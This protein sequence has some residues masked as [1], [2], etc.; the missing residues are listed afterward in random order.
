MEKTQRIDVA[1][2]LRGFAIMGIFL[3]HSVE[4]FN[5]YS[6]PET[7]SQ[8]L[9]FTDKAIWDSLFFTF[10][11][12]AYGIFALLFGFSFF[13][14]DN[15]QLQ[16]GNDF[17]LRFL[18]RL[19]LLFIWGNINAMF[20]TGEILVM[21]SILGIALILVARLK[22]KTV[23]I[24]AMILMLQPMEWGKMIYAILNPEY[25][26]A[27]PLANYYFG[28][29]FEVQNNG[30][31]LETVKMNLWDGQLASLTWAWENA[32]FF[33]TPALFMLGMLIGRRK[34]FQK[35]DENIR[36]W[37]IALIVAVICFFPLKGLGEILSGFIENPAVLRPLK[38]IVK[39]IENMAFMTFLV[40]LI[41]QLYYL[42]T[43][44]H[45]LLDKLRPYGKM[46]LT[47]YIMQSIVGSMLFYNWGFGLH[48][49]LGVTYSFLLGIVLFLLQYLFC[50]WWMKNH[51]HGPLEYI[52]KKLTWIGK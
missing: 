48:N 4:H 31:F 43:K 19:F 46:T 28:R 3:L 33:Q 36:F 6:F 32:R 2:A 45:N 12:K 34:M 15:N 17:R 8:F 10:G 44:G 41:M 30:T 38:L 39:S 27:E 51:R 24:I 29:A 13:I 25:V 23:F 49:K 42:T 11:G 52:W 14:Q 50:R 5:F 16:R 35:T 37:R 26:P 9:K 20:F 40:S 7:S 21:Y 22:T 18:W 1:D 47:S